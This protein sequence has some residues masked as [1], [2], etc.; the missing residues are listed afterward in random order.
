MK[1]ARGES[2]RP[3]HFA[4]RKGAVLRE[5]MEDLDSPL[6]AQLAQGVLRPLRLGGRRAASTGVC[7]VP[8]SERAV[9]AVRIPA[10]GRVFVDPVG[11]ADRWRASAAGSA[12]CSGG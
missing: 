12:A 9:H 11:P 10:P 4:V 5:G 2:R 1:G 3:S 7:S 8:G 6:A